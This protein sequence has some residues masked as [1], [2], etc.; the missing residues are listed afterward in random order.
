[1]KK[2][3]YG[4]WR[5]I[6]GIG[7]GGNGDV[8]SCK[9]GDGVERAIKIL[10]RD[11]HRRDRIARFRNEVIFLD[12]NREQTGVVPLLDYALPDNPD[13]PS[14]YVMPLAIPLVDALGPSPRLSAVVAAMES[15][16]GT[17]ASLA[18]RGV[19]HRDVKPENLFEFDGEWAVG[20]FGLVK[21]PEQ[22]AMTKHGQRLGPF[23]F[24]APEMRQD[25]DK[26]DGE[27]ADVY[28]LAKT[29]WS[30]ASGRKDPPPGELRRD[31]SE[32]RLSEH[33]MDKR[34]SLLEAVLERSTSHNPMLRPRMSEFAAELAW[35]GRTEVSVQHDLSKYVY[36][37]AKIREGTALVDLES[38][39]QRHARLYN[40]AISRVHSD[41]TQRLTQ[42]LGAAGLRNL[43]SA[44]RGLDGWPPQDFGGSADL[45]CWGI[46]TIADK[47]IGASIGVVHRAQPQPNLECLGVTAILA[48]MTSDFQRE[49]VNEFITFRAGSLQLDAAI[50]DLWV[51]LEASLPDVIADFLLMCKRM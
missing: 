10:R 8:Y 44:P 45:A 43:G 37:V 35:W 4:P 21:Y 11:E 2:Q 30:V 15:I 50:G 36:E 22:D 14:W 12:S 17:L 1:M 3:T 16:A 40:E 13:E 41:L 6:K 27:L 28:S 46:E 9:K 34:A 47:W 51:K 24:M 38:E 23:Y 25:A 42:A 49:Y 33:V 31:R 39:D 29:L 48:V 32:S 5:L 26:S 7:G 19:W 20:D 18:G